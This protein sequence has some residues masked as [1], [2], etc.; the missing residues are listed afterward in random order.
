MGVPGFRRTV[1]DGPAVRAGRGQ[2]IFYG[3]HGYRFLLALTKSP[4]VSIRPFRLR[5]DR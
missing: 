1:V 2:E 3:A 4:S 5:I